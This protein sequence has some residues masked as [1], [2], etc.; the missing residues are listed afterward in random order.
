MKGNGYKNVQSAVKVLENLKDTPNIK[1][2]VIKIT[3]NYIICDYKNQWIA[4][5][6]FFGSVKKIIL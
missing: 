6:Y 1:L 2:Y 5:L 4:D 3:N